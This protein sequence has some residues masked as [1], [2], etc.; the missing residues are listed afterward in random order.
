MDNKNKME[1]FKQYSLPPINGTQFSGRLGS[2]IEFEVPATHFVKG[3]EDFRINFKLLN[4]SAQ[5]Q[6]LGVSPT[7]GAN[8]CINRIDFFNNS[9]QL[10]ESLQNYNQICA[11]INQYNYNDANNINRA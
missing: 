4:T 9:G 3:R 2:R 11:I 1:Q 5:K 10:L 8:S 7:A 6:R